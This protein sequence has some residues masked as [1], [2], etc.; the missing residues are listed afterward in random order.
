M[1][2]K[3][4]LR[5][6][7]ISLWTLQDSFITVLKPFGL[8]HKGQIETPK[9]LIKNDGTQ[10]L[11]FK[12]PMYYRQEGK[13]IENPIWYNVIN[14]ALIVNL[15]KLK[16][17][18]NKGLQGEEVFEFIISKIIETHTDGQL[19][20]EVTAEGLAFQELGK[21]G[22]KVSLISQDF[23]DEYNDWYNSTVGVDTEDETFDYPNEEAKAAVEP[24][25][26]LNYWCDKLFKN[27]NWTY[28]IQMDW[29]SY[30]GITTI[31]DNEIRETIGLRRT[32]KIYE[33][34][35]ISSWEV[36]SNLE[37]EVLVPSNME[38]FKEKLRLVD[39]EKS[40]T[41]NNSQELAKVFGVYCKYQYEYDEN[42]HIIGKKCIFYN[43]FLSEKDG[44]IDIIYPYDASKIE[45][46]IDS[47]DVVTKMF[48]TP[49]EDA[50]SPSGLI[51]IA[52]VTANKMRE[53]YILNFDYLYSIGT[54][55]EE[56]YNYIADYERSMYLINTELEPLSI[57]IAKLQTD[58]SN[59]QAQLTSSREAQTLDKEQM[60]QSISLLNAI[61]S[62]TNRL[63]K[64]L[65]NPHRG[66]L[67]KSDTL[68]NTYEIKMTVEGIYTNTE[69]IEGKNTGYPLR[70]GDLT[71]TYGIRLW[72]KVQKPD[73]NIFEYK[74]EKSF[75]IN[76]DINKNVISLSNIK[77]A[78]EDLTPRIYYV[79][80][81]YLPQ[82]HY[83]N[84]YNTYAKKLIIDEN[85]EKEAI[86]KINEIQETLKK[87]EESY[88]LL[89]EN[90]S[91]LIAD[92][93]NMM[94]P[95]LKEGSWQAENYN[96]YGSKYE[97]KVE[98]GKTNESHI[99]FYWDSE[100]FEDEQLLYYPLS[101]ALNNKAYY[102]G[103]NL[104]KYLDVIKN[105][106]DNLSFIY[107]DINDSSLFPNQMSI[108]SE[109]SFAFIDI[110][111]E[112]TP[113]LLLLDKA[114]DKKNNHNYRLGLI[115]SGIEEKEEQ[116]KIETFVNLVEEDWIELSN[117]V[118][119]YPRLKVNSLLLKT[120]EEDLII[121]YNNSTLL[122]YKDYSILMRNEN[123]FITLKDKIMLYDGILNKSFDISYTISNAALSLYLDA[124][125]VAKTNASPQVSYTIE[126]SALNE[127]FIKY[128][129][130]KLNMI[131]NINDAELKF[132]NVQGYISE[133]ELDLE[134][135]WEDSITVQ[136]YKT[137][138]EDLFSTIV[139]SSEQMKTNS[140]A[141]NNAANAFGPGGILKPS[142][143][144]STI[145][146]IDLTYAFNNGNLTIDE[147][148]GIWAR[149]EAGVVAM[150]GGG[151]FCATETDING[152]WLWN[153]GIMPSGINASLI[154]AG[155][156]DT[157]L[158]KI[159]A[160]DNL[161]LQLNADG[162]FAYNVDSLGE[163]DLNQY[164]VHNS[165]GLF[166]IQPKIDDSG[167]KLDELIKKVE[168]S[169]NGLILRNNAGESVFVADEKGNLNISGIIEAL[170][171]RIGNWEITKEGLYYENGTAGLIPDS[172]IKIE[173]NQHPLY[174]HEK[175]LWVEKVLENGEKNEFIVSSDGTLYCNDIIAKGC[176]SAGSFIGNTEVG[177]IDE[178]LRAIS[179]A[180]LDGTTFSFNNRNYDNNY[181]ISP[182][183]LKF[184]I[185]TNALTKD[186]LCAP[187]SS[188]PLAGYKFYYSLDETNW[189]LIEQNTSGEYENIIWKPDYL[190]FIIKN[191][192]MYKGLK[193]TEI[194][195]QTTLY[196]KVEKEGKQRIVDNAGNV[197]YS[198][199]FYEEE[200][201]DENGEIIII[202]KEKP[203]IYSDTIQLVSE[204]I[205]V[206]KFM[207]PMNPPSYTFIEDQ[208][209]EIQYADE[210]TF[211]VELTGFDFEKDKEELENSY[212]SINGV[213]CG[214]RTQL[215][216]SL[217]EDNSA[218]EPGAA[219]LISDDEEIVINGEE[220]EDP[221][222]DETLEKMIYT[223]VDGRSVNPTSGIDISLIIQDE[224]IIASAVISNTIVPEG[225][226]IVLSYHI[227][228]A[229]RSANCFKIRNGS[230]GINIVMRSSSG[231]TLTNGDTDTELSID[232]F[233]GQQ[234]MNS[235]NSKNDFFYVWK[236]DNVAL[237][238]IQISEIKIKENSE[239]LEEETIQEIIS[240]PVK[241]N[242]FA[243][244]TFFKQ[245]TI[246]ITAADFDLKSIYRCDVFSDKE[247]ALEEYLLLNENEDEELSFE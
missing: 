214:L 94:G 138:F 176:I 171:G 83:E 144:Q 151:I 242:D 155:Q 187:N 103:I 91:F 141:Y 58:L 231:S 108:G 169:W 238:N 124:L 216:S 96:D 82:M 192:I 88:N 60:E 147:V 143:M 42:Y 220:V 219:V 158:I 55:T 212:W 237:S 137:K 150:R 128:A 175:M 218:D 210:T 201:E 2:K 68:E 167:N 233:Y 92:F 102:Y 29:S 51:T 140:F 185:Y 211:F 110:K 4:L 84:I 7:E 67:L 95:A 121:K 181:V 245:K 86:Q 97:Q 73:T 6:Y 56:Q 243:N 235:E 69:Y 182:L 184:R 239:T 159:Y 205:G 198:G 202:Q 107:D 136:N 17:I 62:G 215:V 112:K 48:V 193:E 37:G 170:A 64:N 145:N 44:A 200:V 174:G 20:C 117:K 115:T 194:G 104:T 22:Y 43:N 31:Y 190:T 81:A 139:A 196:F 76:Y 45:R 217:T 78:V 28:E 228:Q 152:N 1:D 52:D 149:S 236:K 13:F 232:I 66:V 57:Q 54:I 172:G 153:T 79:T 223:I 14:G 208:N 206:G 188:D 230:D 26:N 89:L 53:D 85:A 47:A 213:D 132:E 148:N 50:T 166:L 221:Y 114:F 34:E 225:G 46:E 183:E 244:E 247:S 179:I 195:P 154:T 129:Y 74:E 27:S 173:D 204:K 70:N 222:Y 189:E 98:V 142:I 125:E 156:I 122:K 35:F 131:V 93:E 24:K 119:Y 19:Y 77:L 63:Y 127:K 191:D 207:T 113:I 111:G 160:G 75:T 197:T 130:Q 123:Y 120:S 165:D 161:R 36:E 240:I 118:Q 134:N 180:V 100:P 186:E 16:L 162:L 80:F 209:N 157:N 59:Y 11:S 21:V 241:E 135:P 168:I 105:N 126:V 38:A 9:C 3:N 246:Y 109:A 226:N 116:P 106:L 101:G 49:V 41:Y 71:N 8:S 25:N 65:D 99:N 229:S 5:P 23:I 40:N 87:A 234:Q 10:E 72:Y 177:E 12:I 133:L 199:D 15:R 146:Q 30:D 178:Q 164:V 18:F 33:E 32:D 90:K 61:T 227:S 39:L 203:H 224:K 163:A